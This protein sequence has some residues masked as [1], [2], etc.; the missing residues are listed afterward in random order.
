MDRS[1]RAEYG[2]DRPQWV[3]RGTPE[4][5][6]FAAALALIAFVSFANLYSSQAILSTYAEKFHVSPATS[7]L[8]ISVSTFALTLFTPLVSRLEKW[9]SKTTLIGVALFLSSLSLIASAFS[10]TFIELVG[11]RAVMGLA[12]TGAPSLAIALVGERVSPPVRGTVMGLYIAGSSLGGF[13]GRV[14]TGIVAAGFGWRIAVG[15]L[16]VLGVAQALAFTRLSG[17]R[18]STSNAAEVPSSSMVADLSRLFRTRG[19]VVTWLVALFSMGSF[20]SMFNYIEFRLE[21]AP[22]LMS[23]SV[24]SWIFA[25][26]LFGVISSALMGRR[27]DRVGRPKVLLVSITWMF[28]G[29]V[30]TVPDSLVSIVLGLIL[31]VLGFFATHTVASGWS[32]ELSGGMASLSSSMYISFFYLGSSTMGY[33]FGFVWASYGWNGVAELLVLSTGVMFLLWWRLARIATG[34]AR[35]GPSQE[36]NF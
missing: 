29:V 12:L 26:Y 28:L 14:F 24:I 30:L 5:R 4:Y 19:I 33:F 17:F 34:P 2:F 21:K 18:G 11:T 8:T 27:I 25:I 10:S 31:F 13:F 22:F 23:R 32:A 16:G 7:A 35:S 15:S 1:P 9:V 20:I 6:R 36:R 3:S